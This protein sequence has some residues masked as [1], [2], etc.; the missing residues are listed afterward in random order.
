V[1]ETPSR[2]PGV[3]LVGASLSFLQSKLRGRRRKV[4]EGDRLEELR[5]AGTVA[6]LWERLYPREPT[7]TRLGLQ[8][9]LRQDCIQ[10]LASVWRYVPPDFELLYGALLRRFQVDN[11]I[12]LLRLVT[13][14]EEEPEPERYLPELPA[15]L[16][17][18]TERLLTSG[19]VE[20]FIEG[21]PSD[22]AQ[23]AARALPL[24]DA[25]ESGAFIE[26]A[27]ERAW[28][29]AVCAA[30]RGVH[31]HREQC[32][33]PLR[34]ELRGARLTA[35]LRAARHY[36]LGWDELRT[37]LPRWSGEHE[38]PAG[39]RQGMASLREVF[40]DPSPAKVVECCAGMKP[41]DTEDLA[42]LEQWLWEQ[43]V[44]R[45]DRIYYSMAEGPSILVCYFYVRRNELKGLTR[46]V[47]ELHY[48]E[49]P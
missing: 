24:H 26:M 22:L 11:A 7:G 49:Q 13:R 43:A 25:H 44:R 39:G 20:E 4:Y 46:L 3:A 8:R 45:A 18:P 21:L 9:R 12:V 16:A 38:P 30:L 47:E 33:A 32:A 27:L 31:R 42:N 36:E 17:L 23:S 10:E 34:V 2:E 28:W 48:A 41:E 40:E 5:Q 19:N 29:D 15:P 14:G 35:V 1:E 37:V 6:Q